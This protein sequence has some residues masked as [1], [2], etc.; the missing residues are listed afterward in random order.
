[1]RKHF[2][3]ILLLIM[4]ASPAF[5]SQQLDSWILY[6]SAEGRYSVSLPRQPTLRTQEAT[7]ATGD[8]LQQY[9]A[10][11]VEPGDV[12]FM[13]AY[14]DLAP[15]TI[16]L[17]DPVRDAMV[18]RING[19]LMSENAISLSGYPGCELKVL[20]RPAPP[21]PAAGEKPGEAIDYIVRARFYEVDKRVYVLQLISPKSLE[22]DSLNAK[23]TRYFDSFQVVKN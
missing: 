6:K 15:G 10:I 2:A 16:F 21:L 7:A 3:A 22:S 1:M 11:V 9:V 8:K 17:A 5:G 13:I 14:Y 12:V 23:A 18:K 4:S 20:T 19:T